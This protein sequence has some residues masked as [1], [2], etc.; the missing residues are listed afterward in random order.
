MKKYPGTLIG[1][2][3]LF[4]CCC[5][6]ALAASSCATS[7]NYRLD[8][9]YTPQ[10]EPLGVD[11]SMQQHMI[12]AAQFNDERKT[13]D[14]S[15]IGRRLQSDG[16]ELKAV[17]KKLQ[18]ATEVVGAAIKDAFYKNSYSV[19]G[20]LPDWDGSERT[21][22]KGW[23]DLIVGGFIE[24]LDVACSTGFLSA[25]YV[26]KVKLRVVFGDVQHKRILYTTTLESSASYEHFYFS[27]ARMEQE[28]NNALAIAI[29]KM[30]ANNKVE[31][32]IDQ[33]T[34]VRGTNIQQ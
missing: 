7:G 8:V 22:Q 25:T 34:H 10:T 5:V 16:S 27:Q 19:F 24:Q 2:T 11:S 20:G 26:T 14:K 15:V 6:I 1:Y 33:I 32:I 9:R 21:I 31:E 30:F 29:E 13:L 28:I 12:T 17:S 23:G 4:L 3:H 18:P